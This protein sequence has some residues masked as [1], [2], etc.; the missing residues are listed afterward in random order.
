MVGASN[1]G[2]KE[3]IRSMEKRRTAPMMRG[4]IMDTPARSTNNMIN[5]KE[6]IA[7]LN[8]VAL[9]LEQR[10]IGPTADV[11]KLRVLANQLEQK[12]RR[13]TDANTATVD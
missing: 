7:L 6:A 8:Q 10:G 4:L 12:W 5:K 2:A 1:A 9:R 11:E 3:I 13:K